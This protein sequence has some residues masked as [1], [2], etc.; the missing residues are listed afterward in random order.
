MASRFETYESIYW[1]FT[2]LCND[3][4][5]HCYNDSSPAGETMP[6]EECLAI[7]G[8][9]PARLGRLILSGGE[10]LVE[11]K[12]LHAILAAVRDRYRGATQ[13][14]LQTNGDLLTAARLDGVLERGV[15]RI[16][17]AGIDRWHKHQGS[18]KDELV[19]LFESRGLRGD[20]V[21]ALVGKQ[22]Y[23][24]PAG[25]SYGLWG[26]TED[27]WLGGVWA[28][29]RALRKDVWLKDG[30][31][32][33]CAILSGARGFLGGADLPQ[34]CSIQ[35]WKI[36]PCCAVTRYPIGDARRDRVSDAIERV[37]SSPVFQKLDAG[38]PYGM[39]ESIGVT[40]A[41]GKERADALGN[42]CLWCDEFMERFLDPGSLRPLASPGEPP[43]RRVR[44]PI[45]SAS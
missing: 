24:N 31:H 9:L 10:P 39:G 6:L 19:R 41:Y 34:E 14:M 15:S 35:L 33:F 4:C 28:R 27:V 13:V 8:N 20:E 23:L 30:R 22:D 40:E 17:V 45:V 1:V 42:V 25:P 2:H 21:N 38:D 37:V 12:K 29:G 16:D 5:D 3:V 26:S 32:N 36:S 18:R 44:L 11:E 43:K 7:V